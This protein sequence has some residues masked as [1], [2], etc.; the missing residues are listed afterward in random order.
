MCTA[1]CRAQD[2]AHRVLWKTCTFNVKYSLLK[3]LLAVAWWRYSY[4]PRGCINASMV[5]ALIV[6]LLTNPL[7]PECVWLVACVFEWVGC[8]G[9]WLVPALEPEV[10][11]ST[12]PSSWGGS[13]LSARLSAC[14]SV[15]DVF[16][17]KTF[18]NAL[19]LEVLGRWEEGSLSFKLRGVPPGGGRSYDRGGDEAKYIWCIVLRHCWLAND[20]HVCEKTAR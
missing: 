5:C 3:E 12:L 17:N 10:Q 20:G 14:Q 16:L 9:S 4:D 11:R 7:L 6:S 18:K 19:L 2:R 1:L 13:P 15:W 8:T